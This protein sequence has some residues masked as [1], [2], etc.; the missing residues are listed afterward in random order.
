MSVVENPSPN[1]ITE[2]LSFFTFNNSYLG[3]A[4]LELNSVGAS[5]EFLIKCSHEIFKLIVIEV[6]D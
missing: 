1:T 4:W 6:G 3:Q 2:M 5:V